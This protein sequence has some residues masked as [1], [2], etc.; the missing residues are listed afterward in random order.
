MADE[1]FFTITQAVRLTGIKA[2]VLRYWEKEFRWLSP[3]KNS[4]GRRCYS[5]HDIEIVRL[6]ARLVYQEGYSLEGARKRIKT[7]Y[8]L[9]DQ[10]Q[11]PLARVNE[12]LVEFLKSQIKEVIDLLERR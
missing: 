7:L 6:I 1:K 8:A 10:L 12:E 2:H 4:S 3:K 5:E 9:S 11:L